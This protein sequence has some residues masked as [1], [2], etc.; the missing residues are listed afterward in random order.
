M[1]MEVI[2]ETNVSNDCKM[3]LDQ[4]A[5]TDKDFL[6]Y[7]F[8]LDISLPKMSPLKFW[9]FMLPRFVKH[10]GMKLSSKF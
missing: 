1:W 3:T 2:H 6:R 7:K 5:V 8:G 10:I 9:A 4:S